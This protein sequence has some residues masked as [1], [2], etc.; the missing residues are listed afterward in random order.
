M[1]SLRS[2]SLL[3][4]LLCFSRGFSFPASIWHMLPSPCS[5]FSLLSC[6]R[7]FHCTFQICLLSCFYSSRYLGFQGCSFCLRFI[8]CFSPFPFHLHIHYLRYLHCCRH[9]A[10][11]FQFCAIEAHYWGQLFLNLSFYFWGKAR[12]RVR[13]GRKILILAH[14]HVQFLG[15]LAR[16]NVKHV[17]THSMRDT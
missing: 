6:L 5:S 15:T 10:E 16:K 13:Q 9:W 12:S 1:V 11:T 3:I 4:T 17:G 14:C 8:H 2:L 7:W